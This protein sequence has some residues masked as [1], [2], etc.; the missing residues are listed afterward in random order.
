MLD[1]SCLPCGTEHHHRR[2]ESQRAVQRERELGPVGG[3]Q[4]DS[5]AR[6]RARRRERG[7]PRVGLALQVTER[8]TAILEVDRAK[9]I[10]VLKRSMRPGFSG[11]DNE[12]YYNQKCMMLFGDAKDS[13]NKLLLALKA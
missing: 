8:V 6:F 10:I 3:H 12:L 5:G 11:V 1:L 2:T 7:R 13:L 4:R 9:S